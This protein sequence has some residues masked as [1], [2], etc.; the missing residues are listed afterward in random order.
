MQKIKEDF[1]RFLKNLE[2][3]Y[4]LKEVIEDLEDYKKMIR[5]KKYD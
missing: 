4:F 5:L 3:I 1:E 2:E